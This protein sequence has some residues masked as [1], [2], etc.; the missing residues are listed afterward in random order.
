MLELDL[1]DVGALPTVDADSDRIGQVL[2]LPGQCRPLLPEDDISGGPGGH[3]HDN[4]TTPD[5][6]SAVVRVAVRDHGRASHPRTK[7]SGI[8]PT[9]PQRQESREGWGWASTSPGP[10]S[11]AW[12]HVGVEYARDG[13]TFWFTL[14]LAPAAA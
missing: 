11:V 12:G 3:V 1:P 4:G 7:L 9:G 5:E 14:P 8:L 2:T 6:G 10:S 13:A